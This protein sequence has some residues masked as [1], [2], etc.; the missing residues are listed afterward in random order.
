MQRRVLAI[1]TIAALAAAAPET[2]AATNIKPLSARPASAPAA[3]RWKAQAVAAIAKW[4]ALDSQSASSSVLNLSFI[5]RAIAESNGWDDPRIPGL[6][7]RLM[8]LRNPDGGWGVNQPFDAFSDG[9][10]NPASTSYTV[11]M[12]D[13]VGPLLLAAWQKGLLT[14]AEPLT[15]IGALLMRIPKWPVAGGH[16][17]AYSTSVNDQKSAKQC[18]HNVNASLGLFLGQLADAGV[19]VSGASN[20]RMMITRAEVASYDVRAKNWPYALTG[21]VN[22]PVHAAMNTEAM[23]RMAP[24]LANRPLVNLMQSTGNSPRDA[25]AHFRLGAFRCD[26]ADRWLPEMQQFVYDAPSPALHNLAMA[27]FGAA[28][29][30]SRCAAAS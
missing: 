21:R 18:V 1:L 11:T 13:H 14:D 19:P 26:M 3:D 17:V 2:V 24:D 8:A 23:L 12:T 16:C 10:I 5:A 30:A 7:T 25:I 6:L 4:E 15:T 9:S 27:A 29:L 20:L 22:D 28:R